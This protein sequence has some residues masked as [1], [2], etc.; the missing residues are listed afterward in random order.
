ML[1]DFE[2]RDF[3]VVKKENNQKE[4]YMKINGRWTKITKDVYAIYKNSYEKMR[5]DFQKD[6]DDVEYNTKIE[7]RLTVSNNLLDKIC[8]EERKQ[9]LYRALSQ[10]A[11]K[12]RYIIVELFFNESTERQLANLLGISKTALHHRK[13][14]ILKK[15]RRLLDNEVR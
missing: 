13:T 14:M 11:E 10:L 2:N 1:N 6:K 7:A 5:R 4:Y 12:E 8:L 15:L 3:W 9:M